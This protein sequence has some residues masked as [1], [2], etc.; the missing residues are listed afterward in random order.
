MRVILHILNK[1]PSA[2]A[3]LLMEQEA[4]LPETRQEVADLTVDEPD[5]AGL[6][7]KIFA[8]DSVQCW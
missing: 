1:P 6:V 5:Y 8:A 2:T 7:E 4:A 3:R